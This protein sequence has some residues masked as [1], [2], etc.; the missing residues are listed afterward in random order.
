MKV[1]VLMD[2][3]LCDDYKPLACTTCA[4]AE[5]MILSILE[6]EMLDSFNYSCQ[7]ELVDFHCAPNRIVPW[8]DKMCV[9]CKQCNEFICEALK[10]SFD[11]LNLISCNHYE[12]VEV[13]VV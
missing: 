2:T 9:N 10:D 11:Y 12:I 13:E 8:D 4:D 7:D 1:Y 5:E 3:E 6:E